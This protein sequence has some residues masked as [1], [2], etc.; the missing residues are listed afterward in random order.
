VKRHRRARR[1]EEK[2]E[3][4]DMPARTADLLHRFLAQG[5]GRLSRR[6]RSR[7]FAALTDVE[8]ARVEALYRRLGGVAEKRAAWGV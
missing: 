8:V 2:S 3:I 5:N 7:D 6:A 1:A 4:V